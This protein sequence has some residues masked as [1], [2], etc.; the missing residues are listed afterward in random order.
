MKT[1]IDF[2]GCSF[3]QFPK[4]PYSIPTDKFDVELYSMHSHNTKTLSSFLDFDLV[5][6][7]NSNYEVNNYGLGS[8]GNFT[9]CNVIENKTRKI[10]KKDNNIAVVQ[11]S[12]ILRNE[13]SWDTIKK[14]NVHHIKNSDVFNID[15]D[16]VKPDYI[17]SR[18]NMNLFY[19]SH[20]SNL[21][22]MME[23]LKENYTKFIVFFGWDIA[24]DDF[25]EILNHWKYRDLINTYPYEYSLSSNEYF[26]NESNYNSDTKIYKGVSGGL[27]EYS[28]NKLE[29]QFR[30]VGGKA[31]DHH[32]SYFSNKIFYNE[33]LREFLIKETDLRFDKTYFT[34][35]QIV[36][37]EEFLKELLVKKAAGNEWENYEYSDL[38]RETINHI[39]QHILK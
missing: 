24:T 19:L 30:Y 20:I 38:Q 21:E 10:D 8:F 16:R 2:F 31:N 35:E 7:S 36:K 27:L 13:R 17:C 14:E 26:E 22:K 39:R 1:V 3:T 4:Y 11:L 9:I 15:F 32:P 34:E 29:E 25:L 23:L 12:A 5:Y 33:I 37:F 28:S 6:N 18:P